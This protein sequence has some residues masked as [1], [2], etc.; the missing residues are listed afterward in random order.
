MQGHGLETNF[1]GELCL[2]TSDSP[3]CTTDK[4]VTV[5][6]YPWGRSTAFAVSADI[7]DEYGESWSLK[8][9]LLLQG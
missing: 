1:A 2:A 9:G 5:P 3:N 4:E 7:L 6:G 8:S